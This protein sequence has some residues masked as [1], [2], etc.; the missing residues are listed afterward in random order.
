MKRIISIAMTIALGAPVMAA[1][2]TFYTGASGGGY[3]RASQKIAA[4]LAQ[5]GH[6]VTIDN[7][8][9]SDD[10]TIQACNS[11]APAMWIAQKD[12]LYKREMEGGCVLVDVGM[13]STEYAMLFFPKGSRDNELSDLEEG[14]TVLVDRIGS[15][16]ELTWKTMAAI[17]E[18]HGRGDDWSKAELEYSPYGRATSMASRGTVQAVFMVRTLKSDDITRLLRA[19][20]ELG[21]LYDK[22]INDLDWNG[23]EL[24]EAKKIALIRDG[25]RLGKDWAYVVPSLIGASEGIEYQ[26]PELFE[27][28]INAAQ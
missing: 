18:E 3:D 9:G 19:G 5:R 1:D 4:R 7:R 26:S 14:D 20:W 2:V 22:D 13:Y 15:G 8:N 12:A 10:I 11:E 21:E 27:D 17:E 16:S 25:R 23:S 24:Y 6:N 28:M